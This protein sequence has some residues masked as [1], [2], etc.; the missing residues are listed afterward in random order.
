MKATWEKQ[1]Q[2]LIANVSTDKPDKE[3]LRL[4]IPKPASRRKSRGAQLFMPSMQEEQLKT[5]KSASELLGV[6]KEYANFNE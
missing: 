4:S 6:K 1:L 2:N 5:D 3:N